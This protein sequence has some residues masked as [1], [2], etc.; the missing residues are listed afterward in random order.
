MVRQVR[1][2]GST[3]ERRVVAWLERGIRVYLIEARDLACDSRFLRQ[4]VPVPDGR[5]VGQ[6]TFQLSGALTTLRDR[7]E[8]EISDGYFGVEP[9]MEWSELWHGREFRAL[10]LE[11]S[12]DWGT[13]P[14]RFSLAKMDPGTASAAHSVAEAITSRSRRA[15]VE[16][17]E[18]LYSR[19]RAFGLD[20]DM[21]S[22]NRLNAPNPK[23]VE[24]ARVLN[25]LRSSLPT[26][27]GWSDGS[28]ATGRSER[29]L[30]RDMND[31]YRSLNIVPPSLKKLLLRE[32]LLSAVM[33]LSANEPSIER[34]ARSVGYGTSRALALALRT[35]G[36]PPASEILSNAR[37]TRS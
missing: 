18:I 32:R 3:A 35:A 23:H 37:Q 22:K 29:Q 19:L 8:S 5:R 2:L 36:L 17:L 25:D 10:A 28:T 26:Q 33:L 15:V 27:A 16:S 14:D 20:L 21:W 9:S 4:L 1:L 12:A 31:F 30:R 24:V 13:M 6:V 34:T 7:R 11:W